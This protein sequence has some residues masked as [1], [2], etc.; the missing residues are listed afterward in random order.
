MPSKPKPSKNLIKFIQSI[1]LVT[2][3]KFIKFVK[4]IQSWRYRP[5]PKLCKKYEVF[6]LYGVYKVL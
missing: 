2:L 6:K 1:K 4:S 3:R 5:S